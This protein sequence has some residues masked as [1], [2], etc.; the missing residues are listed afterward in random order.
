M[1]APLSPSRDER[2]SMTT[3]AYAMLRRRII[4][5]DLAPGEIVT[6]SRLAA[7]IGFGKTPTRDALARLASD[8]LI[9]PIS[10]KGY[11]V[12]PLTIGHVECL[13]E[14]WRLIIGEIAALIATRADAAT[15]RRLYQLTMV[16]SSGSWSDPGLCEHLQSAPFEAILDATGNPILADMARPALALFERV[17]NFALRQGAV[18]GAEYTRHRDALHEAWK[19]SDKE[20]ARDSMI[21]L[22]SFGEQDILKI[23]RGLDSIRNAPLRLQ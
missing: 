7:E 16:W 4:A 17:S 1:S 13:F 14:A 3:S 19:C 6:E 18:S 10:R 22:V 21:A 23:L 9:R 15:R 2:G 20:R 12:V 5:C 11:E 8:G